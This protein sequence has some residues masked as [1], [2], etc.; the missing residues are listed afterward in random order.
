M[1]SIEVVR[2]IMVSAMALPLGACALFVGEPRGATQ[3]SAAPVT[4]QTLAEARSLFEMNNPGLALMRVEAY[5]AVDP[6]SAGAHN[7]AGA[8]YDR[9]GRHDLAQGHYEAALALDANYLPAVNNFGL[10]KLQRAQATARLDLA[11]E[12]EALLARAVMLSG[13][14]DRLAG[15]H[16]T[17]RA[18]L[19]AKIAAAAPAPKPARPQ[20]LAWLE[21]RGL[22]Y[23]YVVTKPSLAA[24]DASALDLD[25]AVALVSPGASFPMTRIVLAPKQAQQLAARFAGAAATPR[26][27]RASSGLSILSLAPARRP[28]WYRGS[29]GEFAPPPLPAEQAL[30]TRTAALLKVASLP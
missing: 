23:T 16:A 29:P 21:R 14:P 24:A 20:P 11:Q 4:E 9:I 3:M 30:S 8:I 27:I 22:A 5:L 25:P 26:V 10:S 6:H 28:R 13:E 7:L 12:A 2:L 17:M 15:S 19:A 18:E 1:R